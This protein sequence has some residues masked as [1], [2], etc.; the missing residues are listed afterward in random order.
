[1]KPTVSLRKALDDQQL[2]GGAL[3]GPSWQAWRV[4]LIAAMGEPLTRQERQLF[5]DLTGRES[6]PAAPVEELWNIVGRRGGKTRAAATIGVYIACLC[7]HTGVLAPGER[8]VLPILAASTEQATRAFQHV[9]GILRHSPLLGSE[10]D[11]EPTA[12]TVRLRGGID[13]QIRAAN[14]RTIRGITA[15]AA[16]GDEVAFWSV[17]GSVNPDREIL[18]ALRPALATTGGPLI[19]I[20]S[21]YAKRG[22]LH[23]TYRKHFGAAGDKLILVAKGGSL[24]FN[25][26]L[27][28]SVVD[29]A[30]ER[31][32]AVAASEYGGEFRS[33]IEAF[34]SLEAIEACIPQGLNSRAPLP[35]LEYFG[36]VDP[37]GGSQ[38]AMTMAIAHREG[39]CAV[40]DYIGERRSPFSPDAVVSEF[41]DVFKAY[42]I[43]TIRGDR[44]A[45]AWPR[46]RFKVRG[47]DYVPADK[48]R[49]EIYLE[50][51]P[52][53]NSRRVELLDNARM[54][55][56]FAGLERR[57]ARAGRDSVDHA[58]GAHDDVANAAAGAI[59]CAQRKPFEQPVVAPIFV[60]IASPELLD[61]T[62]AH[63]PEYGST[64]P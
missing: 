46:E 54:I 22:E 60:S 47:I 17:E 57:T 4:L 53:V 56:Q 33:D 52:L 31:D 9:Q 23:R 28:Q 44:Y 20:S 19:I 45:G 40:L 11:G 12:D 8:G 63:G 25:P 48:T 26:T 49:S 24:T 16:I 10:I 64:W 37:S 61:P 50:F 18:D 14:F 1:M 29:R 58:P 55:S 5:K 62:L 27:K 41:A 2:L 38:D 34:L 35:E 3:P 32:P 43:G 7:D 13:I 15:V 21:P 6:E 59:T 51:L 30:F 39:N 36:F 42:R